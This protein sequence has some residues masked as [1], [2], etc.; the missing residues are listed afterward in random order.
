MPAVR[1]ILFTR[2][3]DESFVQEAREHHI[4]ITA[5]PFIETKPV[6]PSP[7]TDIWQTIA[8]EPIWA[9]F[10]SAHAVTA[11]LDNRVAAHPLPWQ[12]FTLSGE[13]ARALKR[14]QP[15]CV[16]ITASDAASLA[17]QII[18]QY[19][20][21][22][23]HAPIYFFCGNIRR[24]TL[25]EQLNR[26]GIALTEIIVY[27]TQLTPKKLDRAFDGYAFFSPSGV[28]SFFTINQLPRQAPCF[29]IGQTTAAALHSYTS[30]VIVSPEPQ[31]KF[32]LQT[33]YAYFAA[34]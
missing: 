23:A 13:T 3:M 32:L 17:T 10:T 11:V 8:R 16:P 18:H 31:T 26:A 25:P 27:E 34:H 22:Q 24:D 6:E 14:L 15:K 21:T 19:S 9:I 29:A 28:E 30:Q 33:I 4:E 7:L 20:T 5:L 1:H 2:P 12:V